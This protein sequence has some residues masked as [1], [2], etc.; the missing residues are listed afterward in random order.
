VLSCKS[1]GREFHAVGA[2]NLKLRLLILFVQTRGISSWPDVEDRREAREGSTKTG[3]M[4]EE[5]C[6]IIL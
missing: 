1:L 2:E 3:L 5:R 4:Y 6:I